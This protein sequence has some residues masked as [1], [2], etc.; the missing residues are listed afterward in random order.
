MVKSL[1]QQTWFLVSFFATVKIPSFCLC[2]GC[3]FKLLYEWTAVLEKTWLAVFTSS[4]NI[5]QNN[6]AGPDRKRMSF[7]NHVLINVV[8]LNIDF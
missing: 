4:C 6:T 1:T 7:I 8:Y 2:L 5:G 3:T